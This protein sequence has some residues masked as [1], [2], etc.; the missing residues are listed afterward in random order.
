MLRDRASSLPPAQVPAS[1][2]RERPSREARD[3]LCELRLTR[4]AGVEDD[5]ASEKSPAR[6]SSEDGLES[7]AAAAKKW[8]VRSNARPGGTLG[9][10]LIVDS[11]LR[12]KLKVF[13]MRIPT[14][15]TPLPPDDPPFFLRGHSSGSSNHAGDDPHLAASLRPTF[16]YG[17]GRTATTSS[18]L[19]DFRSVIDDLTIENKKLKERLRKYK[20]TNYAHLNKDRLF[21]VRVHGL[22]AQK[23]REL[24]ETLRTFASAVG[25][26]GSSATRKSSTRRRVADLPSISLQTPSTQPSSTSPSI[27][28]PADSAYASGPASRPA[29]NCMALDRKQSALP[30][31]SKVESFLQDT[32]LGLLA[33]H[34]TVVTE[35]MKKKLVAQ[36]LEQLFTGKASVSGRHPMQQQEV[37]ERDDHQANQRNGQ[38]VKRGV[39]EA[40]ILTPNKSLRKK[41]VP[42]LYGRLS[43]ESSCTDQG[44]ARTSE[45]APDYDEQR[46]TR[47]LDL[48]PDRAQIPSENIEYIRHLGLSSPKITPEDSRDAA[49]ADGWVYLNLLV[50]MAQ[51][52]IINV[53]ADF[54]RS[55]VAEASEKF[56]LSRD[57]TKVR[58]KG[59]SEGTTFSSDSSAESALLASPNDSDS[60]DESSRKRRKIDTSLHD[61]RAIEHGKFSAPVSSTS[62]N[63]HSHIANEQRA[64][65]FKP[66]FRHAHCNEANKMSSS[67]SSS[68]SSVDK[69]STDHEPD[70]RQGV[71]HSWRSASSARRKRR[72]EGTIVFYSG[73][74]FCTDLSGDREN[75]ATPIHTVDMGKGSRCN[76]TDD[77]VGC[78]P[79]KTPMPVLSRTPSGSSLSFRPFKDYSIC[80]SMQ[81][82]QS[83]TQA[84]ELLILKADNHL[85]HPSEWMAN[86]DHSLQKFDASGL[87]GTRPAD[88]FAVTV[89]TRRTRLDNKSWA[90]PSEVSFS[91]LG[92]REHVQGASKPTRNSIQASEA[93][94]FADS[95]ASRLAAVR[96]LAA[97]S[98]QPTAASVDLPVKTEVLSTRVLHLQPSILPPPA[99]YYAPYSSSDD[100][101]FD[102]ST[103]DSAGENLSSPRESMLLAYRASSPVSV[104][105]H[106][107]V[108]NPFDLDDEDGDGTAFNDSHT[109]FLV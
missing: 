33:R 104:D 42:R 8:F 69:S 90:K 103:S 43:D 26:D 102:G 57:G 34:P 70:P 51:L 86:E 22:S 15:C 96:A 59:G 65:Y 72:D 47:P 56:Q 84:P 79:N 87:G 73:A 82:V 61:N 27:S 100:G 55:A 30:T 11:E 85:D 12:C 10:Q 1:L 50:N 92:S 17:L 91:G 76:Y 19:D 13:R 53:T 99:A 58:W 46:P 101:S 48:D 80:T 35:R 45:N 106:N 89:E 29:S 32:P 40:Q 49:N 75:I 105:D 38:H 64:F 88:H 67:R 83:P 4:L 24:E 107:A 14:N 81:G 2:R 78:I 21:E 36:R 68:D 94:G 37:S 41:S 9:G 25:S 109:D 28:R 20:T 5:S 93:Q 52:H 63:G 66:M 44:E 54:V 6:R 7:G 71:G 108:D 16:Q 77:A 31:K 97:P 3:G 95:P 98:C 23:K 74:P 18:S 60:L 62:R 39:R